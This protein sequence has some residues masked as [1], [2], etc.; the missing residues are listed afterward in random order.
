MNPACLALTFEP[1]DCIILLAHNSAIHNPG[2]ALQEGRA[3]SVQRSEK[4]FLSY[5]MIGTWSFV[6]SI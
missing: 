2:K 1:C 5:E 3:R 6:I 4:S